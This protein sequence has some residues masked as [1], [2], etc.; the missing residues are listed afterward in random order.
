M[1]AMT[2]VNG[3]CQ[4]RLGVFH[5][6]DRTVGSSVLSVHKSLPLSYLP[7]EEMDDGGEVLAHGACERLWGNWLIVAV[8]G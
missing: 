4:C 3:C 5:R 1:Q 2:V 8:C 6:K 7:H